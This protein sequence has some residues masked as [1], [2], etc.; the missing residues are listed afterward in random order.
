[1][2]CLDAVAIGVTPPEITAVLFPQ[3][4]KDYADSYNDPRLRVRTYL[5]A[6]KRIRDYDYRFLPF[7]SLNDREK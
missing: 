5:K 3:D 2:R 6:A 7:L 1:L 4:Q